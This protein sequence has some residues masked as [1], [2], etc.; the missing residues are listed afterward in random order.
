[1]KHCR[2]ESECMTHVNVAYKGKSTRKVVRKKQ[3]KATKNDISRYEA[4]R[5]CKVDCVIETRE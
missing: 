4:M 1:M 2:T 3:Y 5:H